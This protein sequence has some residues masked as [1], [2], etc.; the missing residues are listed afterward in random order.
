MAAQ[1][2]RPKS[3]D[4]PT[5]SQNRRQ[6]SRKPPRRRTKA[7]AKIWPREREA[8]GPI[9]G[10]YKRGRK[11]RVQAAG[12]LEG[13]STGREESSRAEESD[14]EGYEDQMQNLSRRALDQQM[15][16]QGYHG[17]RR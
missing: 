7:L 1:R 9:N 11:Y 2:S 17:A 3:Q 16:V 5:H 14:A 6:T 8:S 13:W 12:E 4:H 10:Y 15:S